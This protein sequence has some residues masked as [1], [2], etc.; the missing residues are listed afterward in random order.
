MAERIVRKLATG[1]WQQRNRIVIRWGQNN[2]EVLP[3][4]YSPNNARHIEAAKKLREVRIAESETGHHGNDF[5]T[6]RFEVAVERYL[7]AQRFTIEIDKTT[8][9][10]RTIW[11]PHFEGRLLGSIHQAEVKEIISNWEKSDG[12]NYSRSEQTN[13]VIVLRGVFQEHAIWPNPASD[14]KIAKTSKL[15]VDKYEEPER[16]ILLSAAPRYTFNRPG[17]FHLMAVIG[18]ACGLR[19]G[20]ILG[21]S[22]DCLIEGGEDLYVYRQVKAKGIDT[23]KTLQPRHVYIPTWARPHNTT[24]CKHLDDGDFLFVNKDGNP[25]KDRKPLYKLHKQLHADKNIAL[26]RQGFQPRDMYCFRHTRA[27][28]LISQNNS[29]AE[30]AMEL[31]HG[32]GVF[33]STYAHFIRGYSGKKDRSHLEGV[34]VPNHGL[35]VVG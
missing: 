14:I 34:A 31:G 33:Q 1:V 25:V 24:S 4:T 28:E 13:R 7:H 19:T 6:M 30:C 5:Y 11:L 3:S 23:T 17:D 15:P 32:V 18:F 10:L 2:E 21:L 27:S 22:T 26:H 9:M 8:R 29:H 12:S 16:R 35:R 20:E